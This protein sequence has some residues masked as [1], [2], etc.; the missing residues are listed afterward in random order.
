MVLAFAG[1]F[2]PM[3]EA[4]KEISFCFL[5]AAPGPSPPRASSHLKSRRCLSWGAGGDPCVEHGSSGKQW[6]D[7]GAC[8]SSKGR[9]AFRNAALSG[10]FEGVGFGL[11][12]LHGLQTPGRPL[13]MQRGG[14]F[15]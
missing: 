2:S 7:P 9:R 11:R 8:V 15:G 12:S 3:P 14:C 1:C 4:G 6:G 10:A 13:P 5:L